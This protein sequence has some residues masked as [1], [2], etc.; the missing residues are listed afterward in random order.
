MLFGGHPYSTLF[1]SGN[2]NVSVSAPFIGDI[3]N[4]LL[5]AGRIDTALAPFWDHLP[6]GAADRSERVLGGER[7]GDLIASS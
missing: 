5:P 3:N 6:A 7:H 4:Q 1:V 2:G